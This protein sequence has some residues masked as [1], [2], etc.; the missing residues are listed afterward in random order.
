M[1][2][3]VPVAALVLVLGLTL[4]VVAVGV[5]SRLADPRPA[6]ADP[7]QAGIAGPVAGPL[8]VL[9]EW[10]DRRSAAWAA[11]DP[12]ALARLY[13]AGSS[14]GAADVRLLRRY[15]ARGLRVR[16]LRMQL[17]GAR[18][19]ID[20]PRL[21]ELEVTDRLA[22][23]VAVRLTDPQVTRRLPSDGATT[24]RIVLRRIAGAWQVARVSVVPARP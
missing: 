24:H 20:R 6:A 14:A 18:I 10:D 21:V 13:T 19:L 2:V 23:A 22:S 4:G 11:G 1:P 16:D 15:A 7:R 3:R 8:A 9:H 17:L 12:A 5:F